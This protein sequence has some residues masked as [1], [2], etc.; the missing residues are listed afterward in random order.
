MK[1]GRMRDRIDLQSPS[2]TTGDWGPSDGWRTEYTIWAEVTPLTGTEK[3]E[4][5]GVQGTVTHRI[6][7]RY[8]AELNSTWR[9]VYRS[10]AL[11]IV[12]VINVDGLN[13]EMIVDAREHATNG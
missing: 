10:R 2:P 5:E 6:H 4:D 9:I 8:R 12:S 13:A 11:D 7:M 3:A 1:A